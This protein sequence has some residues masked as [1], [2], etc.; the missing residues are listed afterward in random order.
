[1]QVFIMTTATEPSTGRRWIRRYYA[2]FGTFIPNF[3]TCFQVRTIM[4]CLLAEWS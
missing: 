2:K 3:N 1:V 4:V